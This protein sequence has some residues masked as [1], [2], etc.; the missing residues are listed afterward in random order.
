ML[1]TPGLPVLVLEQDIS[2]PR[3]LRGRAKVTS[4]GKLYVALIAYEWE[5]LALSETRRLSGKRR[6][7]REKA[8][9]APSAFQASRLDTNQPGKDFSQSFSGWF[10]SFVQ[11]V[12]SLAFRWDFTLVT[13]DVGSR[14]LLV[15][16]RCALLALRR[17]IMRRPYGIDTRQTPPENCM[18]GRETQ[19]AS[20]AIDKKLKRP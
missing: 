17:P 13:N 14:S 19:H 8:G 9:S 7:G 5:S 15:D 11:S 10:P 3:L 20:T 12:W 4:F 16:S 2:A 18:K 1:G 6:G